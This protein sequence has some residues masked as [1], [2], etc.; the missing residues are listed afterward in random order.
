MIIDNNTIEKY[1]EYYFKQYPRRKKPPIESPTHPSINKWFVM[2][3][4]QMNDLKQKIKEFIVWFVEDQGLTNKGI[5]KCSMTFV[6]YFKTRMRTD[7]DNYTPKFF[8]DGLVE[9]GFIVSDDYFHVESLL[10]KC[11][12]DKERPRTEIYVNY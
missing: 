11:G 2:K 3:R 1:N 5:E 4:P 12:Y 7:V 8:L 10:L 9:S 6:S